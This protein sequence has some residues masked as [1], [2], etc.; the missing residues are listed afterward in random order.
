MKVRNLHVGL[1][2]ILAFV[3]QF[4]LVC[5]QEPLSE[6]VFYQMAKEHKAD[7]KNGGE[8][9]EID[10]NIHNLCA[11]LLAQSFELR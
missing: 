1:T 3:I 10:F 11:M 6:K 8:C 5:W 4:R 7:K 9:D 2:V